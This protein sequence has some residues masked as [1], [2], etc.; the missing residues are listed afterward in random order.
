MSDLHTSGFKDVTRVA[1]AR[2]RLLSV[3]SPHDRTERVSLTAA[4]GRVLADPIAA[5][6]AV[7]HYAR[8]AMDG[9]AVRARDTFGAGE[10]NPGVLRRRAVEEGAVAPGEACR[11]HTGSELP[12]GADAVVMI[13]RVEELSDE[14]EVFTA[15]AEGAN[16]APVGVSLTRATASGHRISVC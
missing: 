12:D 9:Y 13:E 3:A 7:P 15:L 11:V 14:I 4:N 1:P 8:A 10:R 2:E 6:R 16:V 5:Q